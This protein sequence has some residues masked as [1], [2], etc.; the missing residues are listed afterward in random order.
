MPT[1]SISATMQKHTE[2]VA[3]QL[4]AAEAGLLGVF[5]EARSLIAAFDA[6]AADLD[7]ET[8]YAKLEQTSGIYRLQLAIELLIGSC[9]LALGERPDCFYGEALET[10]GRR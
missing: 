10:F 7:D 8:S 1:P 5:S 6:A 2:R 3:M 4:V 9:A